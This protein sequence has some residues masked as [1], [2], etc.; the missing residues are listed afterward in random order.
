MS[1]GARLLC[2][3]VGLG[4]VLLLVPLALARAPLRNLLQRGPDLHHTHQKPI[5]RLGGLII[6][7]AFII[8]ED[9]IA[10]CFPEKCA[11][12]QGYTV[13][14]LSSLAMFG[15]GFWDDITPLGAKRKLLAQVVIA[16]SVCAFGL[17]INRFRI[18]FILRDIPL[19]GW[20]ILVTV[21]WLVGMTNLINLI[22]GMD[23]L[24]GGIC[25]MLFCVLAYVMVYVIGDGGILVLLACGMAGVLSG[26]LIFNF[27][28]ARIYLGDSG[29]YFLGFQIGLIAVLTS[30]K[31]TVFAALVVPLFA[32]AL[33]IIDTTLAILRRGLRG[34]PVFR[35]DR[36]HLHHRLLEMGFSRRTGLLSFYAATLV[37]LAFGL[38]AYCPRGHRIPVLLGAGTLI[39]FGRLNFS[40]RWFAVGR[41]VG[42]SVEMRREVAYALVLTRWLALEGGRRDV[43]EELW[44]D[45]TFA[46]RRLGYKSVR[47]VLADGERVWHET[48]SSG[49]VR[50]FVRVLQG[51]RLGTLELQAFSCGL[52]TARLNGVQPCERSLCPCVAEDKVFEV[53]SDLLAE[54]W[55]NAASRLTKGD[56]HPVG[57]DTRRYSSSGPSAHRAV[58]SVAPALPSQ[59]ARLGTN[60][61][62]SRSDK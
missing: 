5:P 13:L 61:G 11:Q 1:W 35:P 9:F 12:L 15:L 2:A 44:E 17:G 14:L 29:A 38:A 53:V 32:L 31:G 57:F 58:L 22:D 47:M 4:T 54:G 48:H 8:V 43:I 55:V 18:P 49:P 62:R 42:Q 28:P 50:S 40:R 37:I 25:L 34:L 16:L 60:S 41:F 33:P 23:G 52:G 20:G 10:V 19:G 46:A 56:P 21:L 6:I 59:A 7:I 51:G 45:L 39:L 36:S 26:F 24:A 3:L 30:Q 27:P